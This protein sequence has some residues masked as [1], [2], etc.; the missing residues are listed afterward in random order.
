MNHTSSDSSITSLN[1]GLVLPPL[2]LYVHIPWCVKKCP[3]CDFN[4]HAQQGELPVARYVECLKRDLLTQLPWVQ[5]REIHSIFF[6]GGT[7]SLLPA[8]AIAD[9]LNA[10]RNAIPIKKGAEI[11]LETNPG[12]AEYSDFPA[13][14]EAGVNRLSFGAQSFDPT[15]LKTLGRIHSSDDITTAVSSA[16]T[17][18]FDNYNIDL[19]HGLP[20]QSTDAA[21]DD[22]RRALDLE[23]THLSWYQLTIEPNT[24]FYSRPPSLPDDDLISDIY[25]TGQAYLAQQ[26]F[27]QY[28]VSAYARDGQASIHNL[29]YWQFGDYLAIGAGA[30]GK[31][32]LP[33]EKRILRFNKTRKPEDYMARNNDFN[34]SVKP[35]EKANRPLEFM[36]NALRLLNGVESTLFFQRTGLPLSEIDNTLS[37]LR[38][39]GWLIPDK[40]RLQ[41]TKTGHYLLNS[42]LT[43]FLEGD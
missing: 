41:V 33:D 36:M 35:I 5:G 4:S 9:I 40:S 28:E 18:G 2:A 6:G 19:M 7:P 29:N 21:L 12:T 43:E 14:L 15:Q 20:N 1:T 8:T 11:T 10:V 22:I 30:H 13:L 26:G 34:A 32:S 31:I 17:A 37:L 23:P 38:N 42:L 3:Y 16:R 27:N 24:A 25:Q 39:R